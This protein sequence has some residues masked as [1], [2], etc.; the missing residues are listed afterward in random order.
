V[1]EIF[2]DIPYE[3]GP[4]IL[5]M[6]ENDLGRKRFDEMLGKWYRA[7]R[8]SPVDT[9]EFLAFVKQEIA[10]VYRHGIENQIHYLFEQGAV[11]RVESSW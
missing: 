2:T 10:A 7:H 4:W 11:Y 8:F 5:R 9:Q 6:M 3:L 1:R